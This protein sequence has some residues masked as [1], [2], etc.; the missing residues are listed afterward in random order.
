MWLFAARVSCV[1]LQHAVLRGTMPAFADIANLNASAGSILAVTANGPCGEPDRVPHPLLRQS[2]TSLRVAKVAEFLQF[3]RRWSLALISGRSAMAAP[4]TAERK[5]GRMRPST[6]FQLLERHEKRTRHYRASHGTMKCSGQP[7]LLT[8]ASA[9]Q[10]HA[11]PE[12]KA[13]FVVTS[14]QLRTAYGPHCRAQ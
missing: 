8:A 13:S 10:C 3:F 6:S 7:I 2:W 1:E 4:A 5:P 14:S 9:S 12:T 11:D